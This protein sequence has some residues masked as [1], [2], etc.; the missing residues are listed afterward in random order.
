MIIDDKL[1]LK[2]KEKG[3]LRFPFFFVL[4]CVEM[5]VTLTEL[6]HRHKMLNHGPLFDIYL[7]E[8]VVP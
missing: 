1:T 7:A 3:E 6:F 4:K 2:G 8:A 5:N